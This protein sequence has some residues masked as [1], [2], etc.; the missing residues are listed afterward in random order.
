MVKRQG[1]TQ[2]LRG[3]YENLR[4]RG[5]K[6][7]ITGTRM[8]PARCRTHDA[9]IWPTVPVMGRREVSGIR[10]SL[11]KK[12]MPRGGEMIA[13]WGDPTQNQWTRMFVRLNL[14]WRR[15]ST[16]RS[17]SGKN[18]FGEKRPEGRDKKYPH[19]RARRRAVLN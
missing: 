8:G 7:R 10:K 19:P 2:S 14:A 12:K 17:F 4:A 9:Q 13:Q 1:K 18:R 11:K 5:G 15:R 6:I 3:G 16:R